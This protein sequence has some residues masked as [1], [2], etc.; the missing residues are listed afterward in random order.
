MTRL[1][2]ES[3]A[4][5]IRTRDD[6]STQDPLQQPPV[7][8]A[9][10]SK[11][12]P[13]SAISDFPDDAGLRHKTAAKSL[14]AN[15]QPWQEALRNNRETRPPLQHRPVSH[16]VGSDTLSTRPRDATEKKRD[17]PA[18]FAAETAVS[19]ASLKR[20]KLRP[21]PQKIQ[22]LPSFLRPRKPDDTAVSPLFFSHSPRQRP[23]LPRFSSSEA[24]AAIM[25]KATGE[26]SNN[27]VRTVKLARGSVSGLSPQRATST[28]SGR[29]PGERQ[30]ISRILSPDEKELTTRSLR[31]LSQVGI[32]ELLEQDDR[33]T[34]IVDLANSL[35]F[36]PGPI[37]VVFANATLKAYGLLFD[38]IRGRA[39]EDVTGFTG[40]AGFPEF[41]AWVTSFTL[42]G[43]AMDVS[44]PAFA[45]GGASWTC[46]T[47]RR[48]FRVFYG[49]FASTAKAIPSNRP[50]AATVSTLSPDSLRSGHSHPM[51]DAVDDTT[52]E[53][54][55]Y[56]GNIQPHV[57]SDSMVDPGD[58]VLSSV[59]TPVTANK[60]PVVTATTL[61]LDSALQTATSPSGGP[62]TPNI[63]RP[64]DPYPRV[65]SIEAL[66]PF[67]HDQGYFDWTRLPVTAAM[68]K[69]IQ[70]ARSI[71]WPSTG[72]GP[73]EHWPTTLRMVC[74][75]LMA[76]PHPAAMYWGEENV[77]LYNEPYILLAGQK[78]PELMGQTYRDAWGE[79]WEEVK[80]SFNAAKLSGQSTMKDDDRLFVNRSGFLEETY[81]SWCIYLTILLERSCRSTILTFCQ[82]AHPHC[83]PRWYS[84]RA[85]QSCLREDPP[86]DRREAHAYAERSRRNHGSGAGNQELLAAGAEGTTIQRLRH[87]VC[88]PVLRGGRK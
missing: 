45:F 31:S 47:L 30:T 48:K 59:E 36:Q 4:K 62:R 42:N 70:F 52:T 44:L 12:E 74:N 11:A 56:F 26:D 39:A 86:K 37:C 27:T 18:E 5:K 76:S 22:D 54:S 88:A 75:L 20:P 73:I 80:E 2:I 65:M 63:V 43:E 72:L 58:D 7:S 77:A 82:V 9:V 49:A 61:H 79:I 29:Y 16:P 66:S 41:K 24:G 35:N 28:P 87:S 17:L 34:F 33:P 25:K 85:F 10:T 71:D 32:L 15:G 38:L 46:S 13:L 1:P 14:R 51:V 55:D 69:H 23:P 83:W 19:E 60:Q 78:H 6:R 40:D 57:V 8:I 84:S 64:K 68:P 3:I 67:T 50:N 53:P 21:R 81:F